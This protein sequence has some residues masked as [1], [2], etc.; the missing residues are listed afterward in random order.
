MMRALVAILLAGGAVGVAASISI[1]WTGSRPAV[2]TCRNVSAYHQTQRRYIQ[3]RDCQDAD[4]GSPKVPDI[5][6]LDATA[7]PAI[8][9]GAEPRMETVGDFGC[10]CS[11]GANCEM[12]LPDAGWAPAWTNTV[13]AGKWRGGGCVRKTCVEFAGTSSWPPGCRE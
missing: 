5:D 9:L 7:E 10:A 3:L 1:P 6:V 2:V 13:A 12:Q 4:G 11:P 8:A